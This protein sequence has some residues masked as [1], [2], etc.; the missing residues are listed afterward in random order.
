M[1][2]LRLTE[3]QVCLLTLLAEAGP[4]PSRDHL[5]LGLLLA[6]KRSKTEFYRFTVW[7][8][9]PRSGELAQDLSFLRYQ[10][11]ILPE[12]LAVT[13]L[14]RSI[15]PDAQRHYD[16]APMERLIAEFRPL[17]GMAVDEIK[18]ALDPP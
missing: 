6:Q 12:E 18:K 9:A 2:K 5:H 7:L 14:A 15:L 8:D 3:N 17:A 4:V 11:L 16:H 13:P 1:Q 10:G